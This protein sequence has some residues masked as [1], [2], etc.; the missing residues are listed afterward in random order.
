MRISEI[1]ELRDRV[2]CLLDMIRH[3]D[4]KDGLCPGFC[5]HGQDQYAPVPCQVAIPPAM[6]FMPA[7]SKDELLA[8]LR[9]GES[10]DYGNSQACFRVLVTQNSVLLR[11]AISRQ[12][13][14]VVLRGCVGSGSSGASLGSTGSHNVSGSSV[15]SSPPGEEIFKRSRRGAS[16]SPP[17]NFQC[18][19][20]L[21]F[22]NEKDFDRHVMNWNELS[23]HHGVVREGCCGGVRDHQHPF[24]SHFAGDHHVDRVAALVKD[25]RS[26]LHPGAYDSLNAEGSGRH[27]NVAHRLQYLASPLQ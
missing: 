25:I 22:N 19:F 12:E 1:V 16:V 2:C 15:T 4:A 26:L 27:I 17:K 8:A 3:A 9:L 21:K 6:P 14:P 20:C 7:P 23:H 18:P 10:L 24:L 13:H 11:D 5:H